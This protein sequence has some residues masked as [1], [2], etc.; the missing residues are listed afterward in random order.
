MEEVIFDAASA[1]FD[2][3]P[4]KKKKKEKSEEED[5]N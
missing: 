4:I 2:L 1:F 5:E 3:I